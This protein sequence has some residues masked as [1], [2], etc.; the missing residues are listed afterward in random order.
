M[1]RPRRPTCRVVCGTGLRLCATPPK[2]HLRCMHPREHCV[3]WRSRIYVVAPSQSRSGVSIASVPT[4]AERIEM[5]G[6]DDVRATLEDACRLAQVP[7]EVFVAL[8]FSS[9]PAPTVR[10]QYW[11]DG[12]QPTK[13]KSSA[14]CR[15]MTTLDVVWGRGA[16]ERQVTDQCGVVVHHETR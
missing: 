12:C 13:C 16:H 8:N 1:Q 15:R 5:R 14:S 10:A 9:A 7:L 3:H 2:P 4:L 6:L 11:S